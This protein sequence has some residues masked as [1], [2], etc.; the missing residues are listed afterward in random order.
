M[1]K[2]KMM[3]KSLIVKRSIR[4]AGRRTGVS[5]EDAFWKGLEIAADR[6]MTVSD[7]VTTIN[8]KR[9]QGN[10]SSAIRLFV[11]D[12][13]RRQ[14]V[15]LLRKRRSA[16]GPK[17]QSLQNFAYTTSSA[18]AWSCRSNH[19]CAELRARARAH[20]ERWLSEVEQL[21]DHHLHRDAAFAAWADG[22]SAAEYAAEVARRNSS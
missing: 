19:E 14:A 5:V 1:S 18:S 22:Y 7:L 16:K 17:S 6:N 2:R 13:Y 11:L 4:I 15:R 3:R 9:K 10:Q 21:L 12:H 8:S 20:I